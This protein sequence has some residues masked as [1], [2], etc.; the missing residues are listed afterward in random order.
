LTGSAIAPFAREAHDLL[1]EWDTG[2][3]VSTIF[4]KPWLLQVRHGF[5]PQERPVTGHPFAR[6]FTWADWESLRQIRAIAGTPEM[7]LHQL[8]QLCVQREEMMRARLD[9]I[10]RQIDEEVYRLYEISN[11]DRR[12]IE[13]ELALRQGK[14]SLVEEAAEEEA[15]EE[16]P[17]EAAPEPAVNHEKKIQDHIKRLLSFYA[18]RAMEAEASGILT[19]S[20]LAEQVRQALAEEFGQE[21]LDPLELEIRS[22]LGS[23]VEEW[24]GWEFF[25]FHNTLYRRRPIVWQL[26]S[27]P[28][29]KGRRKPPGAFNCFLYY[30]RLSSD[31]LRQVLYIYLKPA[32]EQARERRDYLLQ[33]WQEAKGQRGEEHRRENDYLEADATVRELEGFWEALELLTQP[34]QNLKA[35]PENARWVQ[36]KEYEVRKEGWRPVLDYGVRVNIKALQDAGVLHP[37]ARRI[38]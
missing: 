22:I 1:R 24:L 7:S 19:L 23:T 18:R 31:T 2:N 36:Q 5:N 33:R 11:E 21:R 28:F 32:L 30:H 12:L 34:A 25:P 26:T 35:P 27:F 29:R 15:A 38:K 16:E 3:E 8:A 6:E 4:I 37:D 20:R 14:T 17:E 9:E 13:R 10:Q